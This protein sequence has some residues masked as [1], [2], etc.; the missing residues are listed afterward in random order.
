MATANSIKAKLQALINKANITTGNS[1]TDITSAVDA[2]VGM[3]KNVSHLII[4]ENGVYGANSPQP[5]TEVWTHDSLYDAGEPT[6]V[7]GLVGG[8]CRYGKSEHFVASQ[9]VAETLSHAEFRIEA[10][11]S[12]GGE[13]EIISTAFNECSIEFGSYDFT[14]MYSGLPLIIGIFDADEFKRWNDVQWENSA[15]YILDICT[16]LKSTSPEIGDATLN[17]EITAPGVDKS[18]PSVFCPVTVQ[19]PVGEQAPE[20]ITPH[21]FDHP[22]PTL[23]KAL[24]GQP[25]HYGFYKSVQV[26]P[27]PTEELVIYPS[28]EDVTYESSWGK[29]YKTVVAK[30]ADVSNMKRLA[31]I[32][33]KTFPK[34]EYQAGDWLS[35]DGGIL[36]RTYTNGEYDY[37]NVLNDMLYGVGREEFLSGGEHIVTIKYTA[38]DVTAKT[39][40]KIKCEA[41]PIITFTVDGVEYQARQYEPWWNWVTSTHYVPSSNIHA[42]DDCGCVQD[43]SLV[44]TS[45]GNYL[46]LDGNPVA[47]TDEIVEGG[48]YFINTGLSFTSN[49]DGTC[50]V[51]GIGTCTDK[52]IIIPDTS[53]NGD[54][55]IGIGECAFQN[56]SMTSVVIPAGVA[57]IGNFAFHN[58]YSLTSITIPDSVTSISGSSAFSNCDALTSV[59]ITDLAAWCEMDFINYSNPLGNGANLY[60][61]GALVT[62]L[63]VPDGVTSIG[64]E[65]FWNCTSLT[66]VIIPDSVTNI[67]GNAFYSCDGLTSISISSS[68]KS[69][70]SAAFHG[71][72]SLTS[73]T[74]D[75][76]VTQWNAI[77]KESYWKYDVPATEVVCSDGTVAL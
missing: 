2:L 71:C 31:G 13:T 53:P 25:N 29:W 46:I 10:E 39:T 55:V 60:L 47:A 41:S 34:T 48:A 8:T 30:A 32:Y 45:Y 23:F 9:G 67:G 36:V 54:S 33:L 42:S 72:T 21:P 65:S 50:Y 19:L 16:L 56:A 11:L 64:H 26:A 1:D 77:I 70:G 6:L 43:H 49:G 68:V 12:A 18:A 69:I 3:N 38:D 24:D 75:G 57:S 63:V 37:I 74:F 27:V 7:S 76:T 15:V 20:A 52:D 66:S 62:S 22:M 35:S 5:I 14:V 73:I 61:N 51:S 44:H 17:M 28:T 4:G 59:Y 58:C 40:Y